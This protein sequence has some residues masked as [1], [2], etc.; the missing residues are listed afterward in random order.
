MKNQIF[1]SLAFIVVLFLITGCSSSRKTFSPDRK[2]SPQ[3]LKQ[4]YTL[5]RKILEDVHPSLY[6]YTPKDSMNYYFNEGYSRI[7]DSMTE[8]GFRSL[9]SYVLARINCGHTSCRYS[10][11]YTRYLEMGRL[12][13]FPLS[14]KIW[15][16]TM[17]VTANLNRKDSILKRSTPI[18]SINGVPQQQVVD[19]L[20]KF[21]SSDGYNDVAKFQQL[22]N[23]G[24]FAG[25]YRNIYGLTEKFNIEYLDTN[26]VQ[27]ST[28]IPVYDPAKDTMPFRMAEPIHFS[29]KDLKK[30]RE[31]ITRNLQVDTALNTAYMTLSSFSRGNS[32][33]SFFKHSFKLLKKRNIN[34][35]V[36]DV[37]GNGGGD[38][39]LS[40]LLSR[41]LMDNS[42]KLA[43]SLYAIRRSSNYGKYIEKQSLY[44]FAMQFVT[45]RKSD[46]KYHFGYFER[47]Y[48]KPKKK[49]HYDGKTYILAGGNSFSATALFAA[50]VKGQKNIFLVGEETGGA[51]YGNTAWMI[52][53]AQLPI[54]GI[55]FRV[56]K[57]RLVM[58]NHGE[59]D[60]RGVQPDVFAGPTVQAIREGLD[61]KLEKVRELILA[62]TSKAN[63]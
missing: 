15:K 37:R 21:L 60:G 17:V 33:S 39:S 2:F 63:Q 55:S 16:D 46:G 6:W 31:F 8:P 14:V 20:S 11:D 56:P 51:A 1:S 29:K 24:T 47:H 61:Y 4:D 38:A 34:H 50:T 23:R 43:D 19:S 45:K 41:Y 10:D 52:P 36:I 49:F 22:S 18:L 3:Q 30:Q 25:W 7:R 48:F 32:L 27:Q 28:S 57:F 42:F 58:H 26:G 54:T 12:R 35:L 9:L 59:K 13:T 5:F 62:D 53:D 40:T 44:W